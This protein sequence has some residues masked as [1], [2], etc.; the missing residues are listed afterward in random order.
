MENRGMEMGGCEG[1]VFSKGLME[2]MDDGILYMC[3][4]FNL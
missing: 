4:E 3:N 1:V 2:K